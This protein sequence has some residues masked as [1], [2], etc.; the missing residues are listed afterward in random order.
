MLVCIY[1]IS[2]EIRSPVKK[3]KRR[4]LKWTKDEDNTHCISHGMIKVIPQLGDI[5]REKWRANCGGFL[6]EPG[7]GPLYLKKVES[8]GSRNSGNKLM[9]ASSP[10]QVEKIDH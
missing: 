7:R 3:C 9:S 4:D 10:T 2:F 1:T 5:V 6:M 8:N